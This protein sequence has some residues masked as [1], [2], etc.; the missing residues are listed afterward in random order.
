MS[1]SNCYFIKSML[2]TMLNPVCYKDRN[3]IYLGV[4]ENFARQIA[5]LPEEEIIGYT[6]LET[7][8]KVT[9]VFPERSVVNGILLLEYVKEWDKDDQELFERGGTSTHEYEGIC[10]DGIKR[11]FLVNKSTFNNE[12][13]EIAG[14]VTVLQDIT[15]LNEVKNALEKNEERYRIIIKQTGQV[16]FD[17]DINDRKISW[18]GAVSELIGFDLKD[19]ES[20]DIEVWSSRIHP[21]ELN[22]ISQAFESCIKYGENFRLEYRLRKTDESYVWVEE[23]VVCLTDDHGNVTRTLGVMKD[24]TARKLAQEGLKTSEENYRSFIQNFKGIAFQLDNKFFP[25]FMHGRVEEITGYRE[26]EFLS[27]QVLWIDNIHP[28]DRP[29]F[30]KDIVKIQYSSYNSLRDLAFRIIHKSG[31]IKWVQQTYQKIPGKDG[32]P[33][34]YQG[35]VYDITENKEAEEALEKVEAARKKEIHHRI[36]NNLQVI[37]SL[38]SLQAEMFKDR[39]SIKDSAV[40][41]AFR[42]SQNRVI[43]MALIHEE[44]YKD[45]GFETLNFSSYIERLVESLFQTYRLGNTDIS[46]NMDLE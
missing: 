39:E 21:E 44:L 20:T 30:L 36:K 42:E 23:S 25:D 18:S 37:S 15:E 27:R 46:L 43:S 10:A 17:Y 16:V 13:G 34:K 14:L 45:G 19:F 6:L 38:L 41:E 8:K 35:T 3:G 22:R 9:E 24:I 1:E 26:E 31:R 28:E 5:G 29:F 32:K 7:V 33:D 4:N 12:K 2:D 40:L 11:A